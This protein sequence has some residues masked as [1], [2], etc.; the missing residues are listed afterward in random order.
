MHPDAFGTQHLHEGGGDPGQEGI[1]GGEH[2][3][4][5]TEFLKQSSQTCTQRRRPRHTTRGVG[6]HPQV[7]DATHNDRCRVHELPK[8]RWKL[9]EPGRGYANDIDHEERAYPDCGTMKQLGAECGANPQRSRHCVPV[10]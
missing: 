3:H 1:A 4:V 7:P 6:K 5:V 8:L 2:H 9:V 10:G